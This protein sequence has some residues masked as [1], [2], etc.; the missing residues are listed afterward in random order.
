M[1]RQVGT[2]S[3]SLPLCSL[4]AL[5]HMACITSLCWGG[6]NPSQ[7]PTSAA[8]LGLA[9]E[10]GHGGKV[11]CLPCEPFPLHPALRRFIVEEVWLLKTLAPRSEHWLSSPLYWT[12]AHGSAFE[13]NPPSEQLF[14]S[15]VHLWYSPVLW[16]NHLAIS[17]PDGIM[18]VAVV[19]SE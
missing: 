15:L 12:T 13:K 18:Y 4:Q 11:A 9:L 10:A 7:T 5:N 3:L 17:C 1:V 16:V 2:F 8:S 14:R 6:G 19:L